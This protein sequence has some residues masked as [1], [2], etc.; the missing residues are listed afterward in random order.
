MVQQ[1]HR[2][3]WFGRLDCLEGIVGAY[4]TG[5]ESGPRKK[6]SGPNWSACRSFVTCLVGSTS[7]KVQIIEF[8]QVL[9]HP[10]GWVRE[11]RK[12]RVGAG[13]R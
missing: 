5:R 6:E 2:V 1:G 8:A 13:S 4:C 3:Q 11:G 7:A 10:L 12:T 9:N